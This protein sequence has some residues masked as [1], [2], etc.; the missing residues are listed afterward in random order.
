[1]RDDTTAP[2]LLTASMKALIIGLLEQR[3]ST[4]GLERVKFVV[5]DLLLAEE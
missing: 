5:H 3:R 4:R 1:M 2:W